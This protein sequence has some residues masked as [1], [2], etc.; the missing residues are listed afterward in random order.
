MNIIMLL[1]SIIAVGPTAKIKKKDILKG[2]NLPDAQLACISIQGYYNN[3]KTFK[4]NF[5]Q[6]FYKK[7]HGAQKAEYGVVYVKKPGKMAWE[8]TKPEKKFFIIDSKKVWIYEPSQ[9][10]A[11]WRDIKDSS[12]PAPVKFLWGKG[13]LINNFHVKLIAKSKFGGKGK[14]VLKLVPKKQ[15]PHYRS[16]LFVLTPKGAVLESI[17]YDHSGNKNRIIFSKISLNTKIKSSRFK[18]IPPKGVQVLYAGMQ[19]SKKNLKPKKR[20]K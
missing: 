15:S 1:A 2:F 6:V 9:K 17:V 16:V 5:K 13:D 3:I 8:Y 11:L 20:K 18:F 10:Q 4:A 14:S 12:L 19:A 7:F